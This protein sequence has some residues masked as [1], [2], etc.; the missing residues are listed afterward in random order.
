MQKL[1]TKQISSA[2]KIQ[3]KLKRVTAHKTFSRGLLDMKILWKIGNDIL[4]LMEVVS[5]HLELKCNF[6][7]F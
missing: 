1:W 3:F 4:R 7:N 2:R 6:Y 5:T